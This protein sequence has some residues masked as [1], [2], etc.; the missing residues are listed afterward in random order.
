[1]TKVKRNQCRKGRMVGGVKYEYIKRPEHPFATKNGYVLEHRLVMEKHIGRYLH[2]D[3][4]VHHINCD[5]LD[6]RIEN[7]VTIDQRSHVRNHISPEVKW[8]FLENK[9]WLKEQYIDL[10]RTPTNISKEL[11]CSNQAVRL[12]L[13]RF[14]LREIPKSSKPHPPIKHPELHN[15]T[16]LREKL[17]T[18]SQKQVAELLNCRQSLV[19]LYRKRFGIDLKVKHPSK[20]EFPELQNKEWLEKK[21]QTMSQTDIAKLLGCDRTLVSQR[22]RSFGIKTKFTNQYN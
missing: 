6:N 2:P 11:G 17:E 5:P 12:A 20:P 19:C 8:G 9:Q 14:G 16:W 21:C 1:M 4:K 15:E 3:E 10:N 18:M 13:Q 22:M 7:L